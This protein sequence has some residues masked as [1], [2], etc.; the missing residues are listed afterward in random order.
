MNPYQKGSQAYKKAAV[1]TMDQGALILMLYDG[2]LRFLRA[3]LIKLEAEDLEGSHN[4]LLRAKDIVAELMSSL[5][6]DSSGEIGANLK[7]LYSYIYN[8]LIDANVNKDAELVREAISLLNELRG[9][10]KGMIDSNKTSKTPV[11]N[12][13]GAIK[14]ISLEG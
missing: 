12:Q 1:N 9:G 14:P 5:N 8:R 2:A 7:D 4:N 13:R 11:M 6:L 3:G 10:W